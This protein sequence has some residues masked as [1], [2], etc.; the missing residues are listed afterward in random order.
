MAHL[1]LG[2]C[3]SE[4]AL[5]KTQFEGV[6]FFNGAGWS[7]NLEELKY[8]VRRQ[9]R[10][11]HLLDTSE[12]RERFHPGGIAEFGGAF[13]LPAQE[14]VDLASSPPAGSYLPGRE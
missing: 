12:F 11:A 8:L 5:Y 10:G 13:R 9:A 14:G 1:H 6:E 7:S 2:T 3:Y 4:R